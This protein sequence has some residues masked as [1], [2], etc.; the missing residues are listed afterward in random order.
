MLAG[1]SY[2]PHLSQVFELMR[3]GK[4]LK[5]GE[6]KQERRYRITSLP[7]EIAGPQRLM[8]I[9]RP[10]WGIENGL[11][12]VRDH[13]FEEDAS[14]VRR[15]QAPEV[16]AALNNTVIGTLRFA[17]ETTIAKA[18]RQFGYKLSKAQ[19]NLAPAP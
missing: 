13:S 9:A 4:N 11:H 7:R 16:L 19:F 6:V 12:W 8:E 5:S 14:Q 17:G 15:G 2:W 1:Y 18:R 10:K 3:E